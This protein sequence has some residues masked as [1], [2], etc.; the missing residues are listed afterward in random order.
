MPGQPAAR[1]GDSTAHGGAITVGF[2]MV[3]IGGQPAARLGDMH[4]CPMVNPGTPPPP[5]VGGPI[6]KGSSGV[7]IGNMPA[8]RV[9]DMC[10]CSGPPDSIVMGCM[11]VLIGE[12]GGGGGAGSSS[13]GGSGAIAAQEATAEETEVGE[14]ETGDAAPEEETTEGHFIQVVAKDSAGFPITDCKYELK[15]PDGNVSE[16]TLAGGFKNSITNTGN[17]ELTLKAIVSAKWS[18]ATAKVGDTLKLEA[19][20]AGIPN[21]TEA[22]IE[23]WIYDPNY[24]TT[25]LKTL[26]SKVS[27]DKI[28]SEWLVEV[29]DDMLAVAREKELMGRFSM[30]QFYFIVTAGNFSRRSNM[31]TITDDLEFE[32][33]D[34]AGNPIPDKPYSLYLPNGSVRTG[35]L[36]G[37]GKAKETDIP[38]GSLRISFDVKDEEWTQ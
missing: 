2:P 18:Q 19:E 5:H 24:S 35:N 21:E 37:S 28:E 9:G 6:S 29:D 22:L 23:V 17:H 36:D 38:A 3:L 8:A 16:G 27:G 13:S 20:T 10:I 12:G 26:E 1:L 14:P 33:K 7:L 34:E 25:R 32:L 4:V 15:D 31:L 11:T 30:P